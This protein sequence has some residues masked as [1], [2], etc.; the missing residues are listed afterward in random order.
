M[1]LLVFLW[2]CAWILVNS[3][4]FKAAVFILFSIISAYLSV[5]KCWGKRLPDKKLWIRNRIRLIQMF[6]QLFI[7]QFSFHTWERTKLNI[8]NPTDNGRKTPPLWCYVLNQAPSVQLDMKPLISP[9]YTRS[10]TNTSS[11]NPDLYCG[12]FVYS[13]W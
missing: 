9:L 3:D 10:R 11:S 13:E 12:Y 1:C 4:V 7:Q 2:V 8:I 6:W 5:Q